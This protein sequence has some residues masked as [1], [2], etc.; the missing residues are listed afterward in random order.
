MH[1][2]KDIRFVRL[3]SRSLVVLLLGLLHGAL[4]LFEQFLVLGFDLRFAVVGVA[5]AAGTIGIYIS[6]DIITK[7]GGINWKV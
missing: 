3:R 4:A 7:T 1:T 6:I 5:S 2:R